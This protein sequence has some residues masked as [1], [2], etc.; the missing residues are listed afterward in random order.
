MQNLEAQYNQQFNRNLN[1]TITDPQ[2][3][4]RFAQLNRQYQGLNAFNDPATQKQLKLTAAQRQQLGQLSGQ[5]QTDIQAFGSN[6]NPDS[7]QWSDLQARYSQQLNGVLSP[8]QQRSWSQ[9]TGEAYQ[10]Q[11]SIYFPQQSSNGTQN[12]V[13]QQG[14]QPQGA[15]TQGAQP[16]SGQQP[17][18]ANQPPQATQPQ[19]GVQ[20]QGQGQI[21]Q[22]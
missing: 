20:P 1:D 19:S 21:P 15:N 14:S 8:E 6:R 3:R 22:Q 4:S 10:F 5:W 13:N 17:Q 2:T 7:R 11:P 18:G 9:M 12:G 16:Q